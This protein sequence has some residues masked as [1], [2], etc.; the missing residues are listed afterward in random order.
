MNAENEYFLKGDFFFFEKQKCLFEFR[1]K[2]KRNLI[3]LL[4]KIKEPFSFLKNGSL[5][6]VLKFY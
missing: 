5:N 4:M 3:F 2:K 6:I 1:K